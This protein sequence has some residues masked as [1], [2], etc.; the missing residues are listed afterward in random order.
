MALS[1]GGGIDSTAVMVMFP[2]AFVVHE[3]HTRNGRVVPSFSHD[4]VRSLGP[5]H[6]MLV[7]TNQRYVSHPG[8]WHGWTCA[9]ATSLLLA[10][11]HDFGIVLMGST[12]SSTL[13]YGGARY[14]NR[15]A[16]RRRHGI[17]GN[18]WQ[19][20]FNEVGLPVFSPV[21]GASGY[22]TMNLSLDLIRQGKVFYCTADHG[23]ACLRCTKCLRR[24]LM[25]A[26][27]DRTHLPDW[28]PYDRPDI[29]E[30]LEQQ[31]LHCGHLFAYARNRVPDLPSFPRFETAGPAGHRLRLAD[32]G[33]CSDL[34][35][36][37]PA[38]AGGDTRSGGRPRRAD[39]AQAR[40]RDQELGYPAC[41]GADAS[42]APAGPGRSVT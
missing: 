6:G 4:V 15:F 2:E 7:T 8:G 14:W 31:P 41:R 40:V 19:S 36:V 29:H 30:Y 21:C 32:A 10:T 39:G 24:D 12:I 20:A 33:A 34:R 25:R 9:F 1:F 23:A 38:L 16:A 11:D 3:V 35:P 28:A 18:Y 26:V 42:V 5:E 27:V 22:F 37:R 17:T 13:L